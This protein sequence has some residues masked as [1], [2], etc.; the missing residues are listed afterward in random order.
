MVTE[1]KDGLLDLIQASTWMDD[2][3]KI[4]AINKASL[5][6]AS[7]AYPDWVLNKTAQQIYYKGGCFW[8]S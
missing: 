7:I 6:D 8:S 3:T 1:V 5:M 2:E 4:N